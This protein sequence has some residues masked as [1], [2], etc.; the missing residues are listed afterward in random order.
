MSTDREERKDIG[1]LWKYMGFLDSSLG[2][3]P[4][5]IQE[6]PVLFVGVEG[7]LEKG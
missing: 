2:K 6:G 3:D 4:P 7:L 1:G 5:A